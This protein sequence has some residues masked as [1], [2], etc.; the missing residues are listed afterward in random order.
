M[1][2]ILKNLSLKKINWGVIG[3]GN[4]SENTF[5]PTFVHLKTAK[6]NSIFSKDIERSKY[7]ANKFSIENYYDN[8][9]DFF[10]SNIQAVY[11]SSKN[12][13]HFEHLL[14]AIES[15]KLILTEKPIVLNSKEAK[16]VEQKAREYSAKIYVNLPYLY[17]PIVKKAADL[18]NN[19]YIGKIISI[20]ADYIV[21]YP[22]NNNYRYEKQSGGGPV[23]DLA[24]HLLSLIR[25]VKGDFKLNNS[26]M[27]NLIYQ[28]E[29][30]DFASAQLLFDDGGVANIN[31][32]FCA[33]KAINSIKITGYEGTI[34][35]DNLVHNRNGKTVMN[36]YKQGQLKLVLRKKAN[37]LLLELRE[38]QRNFLGRSS[39]SPF[40]FEASLKDILIIED[41]LNNVSKR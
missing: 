10:N 31:V 1:K 3:C 29:V 17:N 39:Y 18:I 35:I 9:D 21:N 36:I 25:F 8:I 15:K 40:T 26:Y 33:K 30:E 2:T 24:P 28:N 23:Y 12:N 13:E 4:Y 32:G 34:V 22:P 37:N 41:I 5:L 16:I 7:L 19:N 27:D 20:S 14:K 38:I 11:L 6:I